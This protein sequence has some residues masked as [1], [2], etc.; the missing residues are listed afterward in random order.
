[1]YCLHLELLHCLQMRIFLVKLWH[2]SD[3]WMAEGLRVYMQVAAAAEHHIVVKKAFDGEG[4]AL[5]R[6]MPL[7]HEQER[8]SEVAAMMGVGQQEAVQVLRTSVV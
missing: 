4:R 7:V 6:V 5:T 2:E 8:L 1:M 3:S